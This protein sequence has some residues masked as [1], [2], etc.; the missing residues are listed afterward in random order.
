[1]RQE[2]DDR[3]ADQDGGAAP[4][5]ESPTVYRCNALLLDRRDG[6]SAWRGALP[7]GGLSMGVLMALLLLSRG[8]GI[9]QLTQSSCGLTIVGLLVA[10]GALACVRVI[11][12]KKRG[13]LSL[14]GHRLSFMFRFRPERF[15]IPLR[16]IVCIGRRR[17][18]IH[19]TLQGGRGMFFFCSPLHGEDMHDQIVARL[20]ALCVDYAAYE[21]KEFA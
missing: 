4:S 12:P 1:M 6:Y 17:N 5:L 7:W 11:E 15:S 21:H 9:L 16:D 18:R 13:R 8:V 3:K 20:D 10:L 19:L 14:T 2:E